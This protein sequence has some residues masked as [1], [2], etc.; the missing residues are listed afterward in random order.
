MNI[1]RSLLYKGGISSDVYQYQKIHQLVLLTLLVTLGEYKTSQRPF[2]RNPAS[3][4]SSFPSF[5]PSLHP[6]YTILT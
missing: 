5:L 2:D 6:Y 3:F 1:S 4:P